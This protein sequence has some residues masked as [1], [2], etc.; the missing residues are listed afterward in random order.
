MIRVDNIHVLRKK[1]WQMFHIKGIELGLVQSGK[2][3]IIKRISSL[4]D[5]KYPSCVPGVDV[6]IHPEGIVQYMS[7]TCCIKTK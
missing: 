4:V 6:K 5:Y 1:L 7:L 2:V 3:F